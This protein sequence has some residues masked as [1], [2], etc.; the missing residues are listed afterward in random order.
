MLFF[1]KLIALSKFAANIIRL[2]PKLNYDIKKTQI[3][4]QWINRN[5]QD[6]F[7]KGSR[8]RESMYYPAVKYILLDRILKVI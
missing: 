1:K 4:T 7:R 3:N 6:M 2:S 5:P 8:A